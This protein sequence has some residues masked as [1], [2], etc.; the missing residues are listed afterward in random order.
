MY[1]WENIEIYQRNKEPGHVLA[2]A[3]DTAE[4]A[5]QGIDHR[6]FSLN[7]DWKFHYAK[8]VCTAPEGATAVD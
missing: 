2:W 8:G 3:A 7:G 1:D 4:E 5:L 6:R